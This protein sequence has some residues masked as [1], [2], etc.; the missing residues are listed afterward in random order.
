MNASITEIT[1]KTDAGQVMTLI[2]RSELVQS[3]PRGY[4]G[5]ANALMPI[6]YKLETG[7]VVPVLRFNV[8]A[9]PLTGEELHFVSSEL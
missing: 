2:R 1:V 9:H 6:T 4:V 7:E 3:Q 5:G 8:W